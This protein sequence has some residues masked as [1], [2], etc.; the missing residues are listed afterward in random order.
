MLLTTSLADKR[1]AAVAGRLTT[2]GEW[3]SFLLVAP[4]ILVSER[5]SSCV[6]FFGLGDKAP[7]NNSLLTVDK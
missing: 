1:P 7:A 2:S 4:L 3:V 6:S 5:V